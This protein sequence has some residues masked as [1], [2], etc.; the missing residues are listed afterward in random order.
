[1]FRLLFSLLLTLYHIEMNSI[2]LYLDIKMQR[3]WKYISY[4]STT[5]SALYWV[6][7]SQTGFWKFNEKL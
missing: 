4:I 1:M 7:V 3:K 6:R 5:W 2:I